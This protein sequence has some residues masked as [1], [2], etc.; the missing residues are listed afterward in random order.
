MIYKLAHI[1]FQLMHEATNEI[2]ENI[3][4]RADDTPT[5]TTIAVETYFE[6][7]VHLSHRGK[8]VPLLRKNASLQLISNS[9]LDAIM[10]IS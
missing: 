9:K 7:T 8:Q 4:R 2:I 5:I 10:S 1:C 6:F 3:T